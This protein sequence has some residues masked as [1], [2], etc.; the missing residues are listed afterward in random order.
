MP[1]YAPNINQ[2]VISALLD[3]AIR[4]MK[5][6]IGTSAE[7][8][9]LGDK[10]GNL[11]PIVN[12]KKDTT[13]FLVRRDVDS[14]PFP[15]GWSGRG[16]F[17]VEAGAYVWLVEDYDGIK[18]I[19]G[20]STEA[21]I[22]AG[23]NPNVFNYADTRARYWDSQQYPVLMSRAVGTAASPSTE[24]LVYAMF[25]FTD[26]H[27]AQAFT[28]QRVD[29][30]SYIPASDLK[31]LVALFLVGTVVFVIASTPKAEVLDFDVTDFQEIWDAKPARGIPASVW[32]LRNAQAAVTDFD[33]YN[34]DPRQLVNTEPPRMNWNAS[35][36]PTFEDDETAGYDTGSM[37]MW[38]GTRYICSSGNEDAAAWY[39]DA[40]PL[41]VSGDYTVPAGHVQ[42]GSGSTLISG[43]LVVAGELIFG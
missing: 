8:V 1:I 30:A 19:E 37:W 27:Q 35:A 15:V 24:V 6:V 7:E 28:G 43:N 5:T 2:K 18:K 9:I 26:E 11:H 23:R 16:V 14:Q 12:G 4:R 40:F 42:H 20:M 41:D 13:Q 31:R 29:L 25:Y 39:A 38:Q 21:E 3:K 22:A 36:A 33:L 17:R 10:D 34:W 32:L